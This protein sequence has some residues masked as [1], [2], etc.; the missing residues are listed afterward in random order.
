MCFDVLV[1]DTIPKWSQKL[2][3]ALGMRGAGWLGLP[4]Q[5]GDNRAPRMVPEW[6]QHPAAAGEKQEN[7]GGEEKALPGDPQTL[8]QRE[9]EQQ[10]GLIPAPGGLIPV[11]GGSSQPQPSSQSSSS[12]EK[13][14][15]CSFSGGIGTTEPEAGAARAASRAAQSPESR[16]ERFCL[17][18]ELSAFLL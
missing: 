5:P 9:L 16:G 1:H 12:Q 4:H 11:Q 10:G 7:S 18:F 13:P 15:G 3:P 14:H 2:P 6:W 8:G 17:R